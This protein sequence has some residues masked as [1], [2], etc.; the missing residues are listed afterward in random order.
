MDNSDSPNGTPKASLTG[1]VERL[2]SRTESTVMETAKASRRKIDQHQTQKD[3]DRLYWKL[4]K[5]VV[6]LV[7]AG[8]LEHPGV[9]HRVERIDAQLD[10]VATARDGVKPD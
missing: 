4:G 1:F 7:R 3:L 6:E 2:R 5:E 8:E 9:R 10:R